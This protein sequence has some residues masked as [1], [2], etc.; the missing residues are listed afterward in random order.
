MTDDLLVKL[1]EKLRIP[2]ALDDKSVRCPCLIKRKINRGP[3]HWCLYLGNKQE[4]AFSLDPDNPDLPALANWIMNELS[5][6]A[7]LATLVWYGD[8]KQ[9]W[10][11]IF[12]VEDGIFEGKGPTMTDAIVEAVKAWVTP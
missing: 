3:W 6:M 7:H 8:N 2:K 1:A 10:A 5:K 9:M 12:H 11:Y 4:F